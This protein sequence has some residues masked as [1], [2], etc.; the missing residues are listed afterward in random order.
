MLCLNCYTKYS[1]TAVNQRFTFSYTL[2]NVITGKK[3]QLIQ[4]INRDSLQLNSI[5]RII[6]F[7]CSY[8]CCLPMVTHY[9]PC[10]LFVSLFDPQSY[11]A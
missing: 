8:I 5:K 9:W 4:G 6:L 3:T 1:L 7:C 11:F 10:V 2:L